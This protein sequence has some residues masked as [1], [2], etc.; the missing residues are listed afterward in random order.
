MLNLSLCDVCDGW[1]CDVFIHIYGAVVVL[2]LFIFEIFDVDKPMFYRLLS[3]I[4]SVN[5]YVN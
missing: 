5:N 4:I 3:F 1:G 2:R